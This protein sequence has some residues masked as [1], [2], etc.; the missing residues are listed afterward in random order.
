MK[1]FYL[2][3]LIFSVFTYKD[4]SSQS[5]V[6]TNGGFESPVIFSGFSFNIAA[7][8]PAAVI[9]TR[10]PGWNSTAPDYNIEQRKLGATSGELSAVG[11]QH[12]ELNAKYAAR[13]YQNMFLV[14]GENMSYSYY[15]QGR[16]GSDTMELNIYDLAGTTKLAILKSSSTDSTGW[17]YYRGS[18]IVGLPT[19]NYQVSL[20]PKGTAG[21]LPDYGNFVDEVNISFTPVVTFTKPNYSAPESAVSRPEI[22]VSGIV[23]AGGLTVTFSTNFSNAT[24]GTDFNLSSLTIPA[25]QYT[26]KSDSFPIPL[27]IVNDN[28]HELD[29]NI[30]ISISS[31]S[32]GGITK[33]VAGNYT[34][35]YY[36]IVNDDALYAGP[37]QTVCLGDSVMV[38]ATGRPSPVWDKGVIQG[39]NFA[40]PPLP[41]VTQYIVKDSI[42]SGNL[43]LNPDFS[44]GNS[45]F[46]SQYRYES[47]TDSTF[48]SRYLS[49]TDYNVVTDPKLSNKFQDNAVDHT[50]GSGKMLN[51]DGSTIANLYLWRET[52]SVSPNTAY[53]FSIWV[54]D[55]TGISS[56]ILQFTIN[57][58][59]IGSLFTPTNNKV[60]EQ[61]S[62]SWNSGTNT[63]ADIRIESKNLT[64]FGNDFAFDDVFFGGW[65]KFFDTLQI[66]TKLPA[67]P[68]TKNI[69]TCQ[70]SGNYSLTATGTNLTW[71]NLPTGITGKTTTA[72]VYNLNFPDT[73]S[74]WVSQTIG[75]CESPRAQISIAIRKI[76]GLPTVKNLDTCQTAGSYTLQ[77]SGVGLS[78]YTLATGGTS[79]IIAPVVNLNVPDTTSHWVSQTLNGCEGPRAKVDVMI[80]AL[81]SAPVTSNLDTC[82][83]IGTYALKTTG[84]GLGW[85]TTA[86]L[87]TRV[88]ATPSFNLNIPDTTSRWVSQILNGCEGPRKQ[89]TIAIRKTPGI[90][91]VKSLDTCQTTGSYTLQAFGVG[92]GWYTVATGGTSS[93]VAPIFNLNVPDTTFCWVSQTLN[94]CEGPRSKADV[95][96]K[97][98]PSAPATINLDTCQT[99]GTYTLKA[100]GT[101]L[102]WYATATL[103]TRLT[104]TPTFNLNMPDTTAQWV[105]QTLNGCE[106]PRSQVDVAIR[107][108]PGLPVLKNI[109]TCQQMGNISLASSGTNLKWYDFSSGG[110]ASNIVPVYDLNIP[111]NT[112]KWVSQGFNG[113]EGPRLQLTILIKTTPAAPA[114]INLDTCQTTGTY[115]L[116]A[117]GTGLSWYAS[118]TL[119]TRLTATPTL[120]LNMPDTTAQWVSQTM[121][122]CE[123]PTS[124]VDVAIR[125]I[126]GLPVLKNIDTCQQMGNISL[127]SSGTNLKWYDFSSGGTASNIVPVFDLNI[128]INTSKWVSQGF[129]GCEG[130]R[131]QLTILIKTPPV[132]PATVNLDTCR[133]SGL[134]TAKASGASL[135]WYDVS[136]GGIANTIAPVFYLNIPDTTAK[137]V[138]QTSNGCES[139]RAKVLISV[140][141][142]P[143]APLTQ[144]V[145]VCQSAGNIT[146]TAT[147]AQL[148]WYNTASGGT[149]VSSPDFPISN[150]DTVSLWVSQTVSLCEGPRSKATLV[151]KALPSAPLVKDTTL[152]QKT[153]TLSFKASGTSLL[154]YFPGS[155]AGSG[156]TPSV[157]TNIAQATIYQVSQTVNGCEGLKSTETIQINNIPAAPA[158][159]DQVICESTGTIS[160]LASGIALQWYSG[161]TITTFTTQAP[162]INRNDIG[163]NQAFVSQT[164]NSCESFRKLV[165]ITV[166]AL[167]AAPL[168]PDVKYCYGD[169]ARPLTSLKDSLFWYNVASG[170]IRSTQVPIP[171]TQNVSV[172]NYWVS[173]VV[174]GCESPR[175]NVKAT[176]NTLPLVLITGVSGGTYCSK[177]KLTFK[178]TGGISYDWT[179]PGG[180]HSSQANL[181]I[182]SFGAKD[183]GKYVL[184][185]TD[186]NQCSSEE[187]L[188]LDIKYPPAIIALPLVVCEKEPIRIKAGT[189][190]TAFWK[191]PG[192]RVQNSSDLYL[193]I[194]QYSDNGRYVIISSQNG[195]TDSLDVFISVNNCKPKAND[196]HYT[197]FLDQDLILNAENHPIDNDSDPNDKLQFEDFSFITTPRFGTLSV[198]SKGFWTYKVSSEIDAVE[199]LEYQVCDR[200]V[201]K[202]CDNAKV[203]IVLKKREAFLPDAFTPNGDGINDFYTVYHLS[204]QVRVALNVFNR[205]GDLVYRNADYKNDWAG[206]CTQGT[207]QGSELPVGT[208]YL[209]AELS[210]GVKYTTHLTL[211]R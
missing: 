193:P 176:V 86:T 19:G 98:K 27:T 157:N 131:L 78:W 65:V 37:D 154:W 1:R 133:T 47:R 34:T 172:K 28:I 43:I 9:G 2:I 185:G 204:P 75:G 80:K 29:E 148:K 76:P 50:T 207:C 91:T 195:C 146:L 104:A 143:V 51:V 23:P 206:A 36:N 55:L 151:V 93:N 12:I 169:L 66:I 52:I 128:P 136:S 17:K 180:Q 192:N 71:Y 147:G 198:D 114:T 121:N 102:A 69:D 87:G 62:Q 199:I 100:T 4:V 96:I 177:T 197:A 200:G 92:L 153:G 129:N 134:Y 138:T 145:S 107:K 127:T 125:K 182:P 205:W 188:S 105:S 83:T 108:I 25:G 3:F 63:T 211:N 40:S 32:S 159:I 61:F 122:G 109:D 112:S 150:P 30:T 81:P 164:I 110:T 59:V 84:T 72:P 45:G 191:L 186:I 5:R 202:L 187:S 160:Y 11:N 135:N 101:G 64:A 90:P 82:Q 79:S 162:S 95:I 173:A 194:S 174:K 35:T 161:P 31:V 113:C 190:G 77:A 103:G 42:Y 56:P 179:S 94:G 210:N 119:G 141:A 201:P 22:K 118:A 13:M 68:L 70:Q 99:T 142:L 170:G 53:N 15:H 209:V 189:T 60:W 120:N 155:T 163:I 24:S 7:N 44:L 111:I 166:N 39:K 124:Q 117:T 10:V 20:E 152:C 208:Y 184:K 33:D 139:P 16:Y 21:G 18:Y 49:R 115:T 26:T 8:A 73:T 58:Q 149:I 97:V 165:K 74:K 38:N 196:D 137:W 89:L 132:V 144:D 85:Y 46:M 130:P 57:G 168:I 171:N 48:N 181:V 41:G 140:K 14:F 54:N 203:E 167:P 175:A 67:A 106:G 178:A 126:P 116:K 123:G 183:V 156:L 158:G 88:T 6:L